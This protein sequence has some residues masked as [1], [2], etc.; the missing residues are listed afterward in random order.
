MPDKEML[1]NV[2]EGEEVRIAVVQ[3]GRL[4]ELY[5]ER[6]S[7]ESHVGNIYKG[8]VVNVEPSIQAAF[9]DFGQGKNGF[10][11]ISDLQPQYFP[12]NPTKEEV[13]KKTSRRD[14]PPIQKCLRRGQEIIVQVTKEGI[15]TKGPTLTTY[16]SI[17]G[18]FLVLMPGM[19]RLGVSRK[20]EDEDARRS[21]RRQLDELNPPKNMGFIVR[22]AG[23]GRPKRELQR[24]LNYLLRLWKTVAERIKSDKT[25]SELYQESDLVTRTIRDVFNSDIKRFIVDN[26]PTY[27]R[28]KDFLNIALPRS[29]KELVQLYDDPVPLFHRYNIEQELEKINS[30]HVQLSTGGSLV[31]DQTEALVA[32]DVNSGKY[33]SMDD[34]EKTAYR[35]DLEA[36]S[37]VARQ[38][39]LRD[40]GGLI[41]I[42]FID[43]RD[44]HH[45]REVERV[46]REAIKADRA[47]SEILR[48]SRFGI[49]EMTRQRMRPSLERSLYQDCPH[50]RGFGMVKSPE[51]LSFDVMRAIQAAVSRPE[52]DRV[53]VT[54]SPAAGQ[55]L[56]NRK[57]RSL[58]QVEDRSGKR[59]I[60][61]MDE[62]LG[63][64]EVR[65]NCI[66][67]RGATISLDLVAKPPEPRPR[68]QQQQ[69][70]HHHRDEDR[71][72]REPHAHEP[73][74]LREDIEDVE[75]A[76]DEPG[77]TPQ[78]AQLWHDQPD[79]DIRWQDE[80]ADADAAPAA[81]DESPQS[82]RSPAGPLPPAIMPA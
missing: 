51:S 79:E 30:R 23:I 57:R 62:K 4:E 47:R 80:P 74:E 35:T 49:V 52:V 26:Q 45:Q 39:R 54:V 21:V 82:E 53:E 24:D 11:H 41:I 5:M 68:Q 18:R 20:V 55:Y 65:Y 32:I 42:D 70:Q 75:P 16:L 15:G 56:H 43:L 60:I 73:A 78:P 33:R 27:Q 50:C 76:P 40:L 38:L 2:V 10:L 1:I 72:D 22:T 14:R 31:I 13:G 36:A 61:N 69:P 46:L 3:D 9:I 12:G 7:A 77:A 25:P 48:M 66:D 17:P 59:V 8:R 81:G 44:G 63:Q 71:A 29:S 34:A 28:V 67:K 6:A 64:D 19:S 37:E 58:I